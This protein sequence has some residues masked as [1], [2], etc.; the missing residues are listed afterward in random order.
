MNEGALVPFELTV[1]VLINGMIANPAKVRTMTKI[2]EF[3][4]IS[5]MDS[6]EQSIKQ[7]TLNST[8]QSAK[9]S[10]SMMYQKRL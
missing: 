4:I 9:M 7:S 5:L 2:Y 3:R 6:Q 1:E 10:S 8:L